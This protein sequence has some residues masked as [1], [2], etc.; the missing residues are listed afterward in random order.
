M[1]MMRIESVFTLSIR[2]FRPVFDLLTYC[3]NIGNI[4]PQIVVYG[5][6]LNLSL[7]FVSKESISRLILSLVIFA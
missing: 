5:I 1:D 4:H 2:I 7:I 3:R 6:I